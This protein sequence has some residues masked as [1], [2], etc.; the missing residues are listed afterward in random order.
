MKT[1]LLIGCLLFLSSVNAQDWNDYT[2]GK[3][4]DDATD[5]PVVFASVYV[6]GRPLGVITNRDGSFRFPEVYRTYG[7]T[8]IVSSMGYDTRKVLVNTL[9]KGDINIIRLKPG[10]ERLEEVVVAADKRKKD[11]LSARRIIR[12]A[13]KAIPENYPTTS[14]STVG[15]YR[16][17]QFK[18][19]EYLNLNEAILEVFDQGF[20]QSDDESTKVRI[21]QYKANPDFKKDSLA[22]RPYNYKTWDKVIAN[23]HL[24]GFGG[25]E[26][27]I[28]R[29]HDAI[30][31]YDVETYDFVDVL[32]KKLLQ[33]HSFLKK[34]D[35]YQDNRSFYAVRVSK[36]GPGYEAKGIFTIS[37]RDFGIHEMEYEVNR[38]KAIKNR[39]KGS[40]LTDSLIFRVEVNYQPRTGKLYP[41][42]ISFQNSFQVKR[43][44]PFIFREGMANLP[45]GYFMFYFNKPVEPI[46]GNEPGNYQIKF[47]KKSI[48]IKEVEILGD[49]VR[50]FPNMEKGPLFNMMR[51]IQTELNKRTPVEEILQMSVDDV[52]DLT[53]NVV[54]RH[55]FDPYLQ[56]R[57]YFVQQVK[58][59]HRAP[60]DN[61]F[62]EKRKPIH[63]EQPRAKPSDST[64]Y[65]K[66]TPLREN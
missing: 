50:V 19:E 2:T 3:V 25:N 34:K 32:S 64:I 28:L 41:N 55:I 56:F 9:S 14:F 18:D 26:F 48:P 16:D 15:Y 60:L 1:I 12:K 10:T 21:Y 36:T 66:N 11:R 35:V 57:E 8:L 30:R 13:I 45:S 52:T 33:D 7:D 31:N 40:S 23:A 54:N 58:P 43:P 63:E 42:Y 62:M 47:K 5:E 37:K 38:T 22:S 20:D 61:L 29:I 27:Y 49:S 39:D 46:S 53:G 59:D 51:E 17:Y 6:Q 24:E 44:P 65:W 4:L